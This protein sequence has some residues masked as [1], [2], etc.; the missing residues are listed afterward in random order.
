MAGSPAEKAGLK[1]GD[2]LLAFDGKEV[3]DARQLQLV[4]ADTPVGRQVMVEIFR[5]NRVQKV[6]LQLASADSVEAKKPKSA[7][8]EVSG[9]MGLEVEELPRSKAQ[10]GMTGVI[11]TA[12]DPEGVAAGSGIQRG[13]IVTSVNR[14]K[15]SNL[16]DYYAAMKDAEKRGSVA[17]LVRRGD[18]S[19]YFAIKLR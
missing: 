17:L 13:D 7:K 6:G 5:D 3:K 19:I 15:I 18:A 14:K 2:I 12:V 4:V 16:P 8:A 9:V 1:Q 10:S 11:V